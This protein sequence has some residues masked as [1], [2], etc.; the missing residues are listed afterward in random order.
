MKYLFSILFL[1]FSTTIIPQ[2][3]IP[4]D[5]IV[6]YANNASS[7]NLGEFRYLKIP[8]DNECHDTVKGQIVTGKQ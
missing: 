5:T 4:F 8:L 6:S 3:A 7:G 1:F 2:P